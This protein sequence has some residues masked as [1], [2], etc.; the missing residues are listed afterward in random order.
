MDRI[1]KIPSGMVSLNELKD[2]L[3]INTPINNWKYYLKRYGYLYGKKTQN[4]K[5]PVTAYRT[6]TLI[7]EA[8]ANEILNNYNKVRGRKR[9]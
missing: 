2:M 7:S 5:M 9:K 4:V 3:G 6:V 1:D 8:D